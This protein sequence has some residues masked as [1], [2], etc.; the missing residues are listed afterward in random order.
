MSWTEQEL[1]AIGAAQE[2]EIAPRRRNGALRTPVPIWAVRAG[3]DIFVR[4][5]YGPGTG[6]FRVARTSREAHVRAGG[7]ERDVLVEDADAAVH[8]E[9]DAAYRTKYGRYASIV[10]GITNDEAR[11]TTLRLVPRA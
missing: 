7:V 4:A 5:A 6:W 3:E 9:V 1:A 10:D 2:L 8:D 11:P